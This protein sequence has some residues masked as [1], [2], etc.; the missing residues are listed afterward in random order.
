MSRSMTA[1]RKLLS[2]MQA[3]GIADS[4]FVDRM[5]SMLFSQPEEKKQPL[6]LATAKSKEK[7]K[8]ARTDK[9]QAKSRKRKT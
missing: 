9:K 7:P 1:Y 3:E 2:S 6:K 8:A 4:P 5:L